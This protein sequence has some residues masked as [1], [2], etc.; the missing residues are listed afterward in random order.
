MSRGRITY[1][2]PERER[3]VTGRALGIDYEWP[4]IEANIRHRLEHVDFAV[5]ARPSSHRSTTP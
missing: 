5:R 3:N 1:K 2:H 4:V